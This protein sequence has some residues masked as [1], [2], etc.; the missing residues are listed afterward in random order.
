MIGLRF[1]F[2]TIGVAP[3][4]TVSANPSMLAL[5]AYLCDGRMRAEIDYST[6]RRIAGTTVI[7]AADQFDPCAISNFIA[8]ADSG[9]EGAERAT[10][11]SRFV[12]PGEQ[13]PA[14]SLL[15][16]SV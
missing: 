3:D 13:R 8:L 6:C 14:G 15:D 12:A 16:H 11:N 9:G 4:E 5:S 2:D 1:V 10:V 7:F